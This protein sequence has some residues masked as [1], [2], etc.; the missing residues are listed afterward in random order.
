MLILQRKE[1]QI[2]ESLRSLARALLLISFGF[3]P[4]GFSKQALDNAWDGYVYARNVF[5]CFCVYFVFQLVR[6]DLH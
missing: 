5:L 3:I 4:Y 1:V 2:S 6:E